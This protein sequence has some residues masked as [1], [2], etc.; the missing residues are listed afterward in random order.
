MAGVALLRLGAVRANFAP[1]VRCE[2]DHCHNAES[3]SFSSTGA[4]GEYGAAYVAGCHDSTQHLWSSVEGPCGG[5]W[6]R[7]N[8]RR[9]SRELSQQTSAGGLFSASACFSVSNENFLV[10]LVGRDGEPNFC[11]L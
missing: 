1:G 5:K 4:S 2:A 7:G 6:D 10:D 9:Q 3:M 8:Q 11:P